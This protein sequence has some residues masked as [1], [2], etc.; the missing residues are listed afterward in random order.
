MQARL[1]LPPPVGAFAAHRVLAEGLGQGAHV[2]GQTPPPSL[3]GRGGVFVD[4]SGESFHL[5]QAVTQL[6][7]EPHPA[8][9]SRTV[10]LPQNAMWFLIERA[11]GDG[12]R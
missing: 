1:H 4:G 6:C 2:F 3:Q 8:S 9:V 5:T 12:C 10:T 7:G 11:S